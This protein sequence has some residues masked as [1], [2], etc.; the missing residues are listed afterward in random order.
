M[1]VILLE[2]S[3]PDNQ[4][5]FARALAEVGATVIGIGERPKDWLDD[6]VKEW[7]SHYEQVDS[8]TNDVAV[9]RAVRWVQERVWVDRLEATIE[10]HTMTAARVREACTIPGTSVRTAFLC[11]DKPAMKEVLR[12]CRHPVRTVHRHEPPSP[13]EVRWPSPSRGRLPAHR[14]AARRRG[15]RGHRA[16]STSDEELERALHVVERSRTASSVALEEFIEGHEGF[17]D[18]I[19]IDGDDRPRVHLPLL[20]ERA[21]GRCAAAGS[22]RRS[23][24]RTASTPTPT[25]A[26]SRRSARPGHRRRSGIGTSATHMEWFSGPKGLVFS[27]IGCRPPGVRAWDLYSVGNDLDLYREWAQLIVHGTTD[28][29]ASRRF[30]AGIIALRPERRARK[31]AERLLESK[32]RELYSVNQDLKKLA[33][34]LEKLVQE[35]TAELMQARDDALAANRSKSA[36]LANMSHEI[37]TPMSGVIG[38]VELL[39]DT[40]LNSE[41]R[42]QAS[43][44]LS[45]ARSLLGIINDILDLSKLEAGKL[46]LEIQD[47]DLSELLDEVFDTLA[48]SASNKCLEIGSVEIDAVPRRVRG[49][50]IRLRQILLNLI[51]NAVK[52]TERGGVEVQVRIVGRQAEA[53]HVRFDIVDSGI[54]IEPRD[55]PFLFEKFSQVDTRKGRRQMGTGL[56]LA[57]SRS[58]V[59]LMGGDIGVESNP[60]TGS[61]FWF[62]VSLTDLSQEVEET[63]GG[64]K[65]RVAGFVPEKIPRAVLSAHARALGADAVIHTHIDDFLGALATSRDQQRPYDVVLVSASPGPADDASRRLAKQVKEL[66][67]KATKT[68]LL[69]WPDGQSGA[70]LTSWETVVSRPVTRRKLEALL[71]RDAAAEDHLETVG[72]VAKAHEVV[73]ISDKSRPRLLLVEDVFSLQMVTRAYLRKLGYEADVVD[74]GHEALRLLQAGEYGLVLM[75]IHM[76]GMDGIAAT[77]AIRQLPDP[78]CATIPV[79][80]LTAD[81]MKGDEAECLQAGMNDYLTKPIN[82]KELSEKLK[83]WLGSAA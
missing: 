51:G 54:G 35:R 61:R 30:A 64:A 68:V 11:R 47:F 37:R 21:R 82:A 33:S 13:E 28:R 62:A 17:Y 60:G 4:K 71:C 78:D 38:M 23:W 53:V 29:R 77:K 74:N 10:A 48:I 66:C 3:F 56:G 50:P 2:P 63:I 83:L 22:R 18:T 80:A 25:T 32:S 19:S 46:P 65:L 12:R 55:Q 44:I 59:S 7:L 45:S 81:A 70:S 31:E 76:P 43:V 39:L 72:D 57:I 27:E 9:E 24:R 8:V 20:P 5:Q 15:R 79:I 67:P 26:R 16:A 69:A 6:D 75:D 14:Q 58:L 73:E 49:D 41:Q 52:F 42:H 36:F 1:N 40:P 34:N